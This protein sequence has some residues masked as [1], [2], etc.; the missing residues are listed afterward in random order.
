MSEWL[1]VEKVVKEKNAAILISQDLLIYTNNHNFS[2]HYCCKET[3]WPGQ[4]I[5]RKI[6]NCNLFVVSK[7]FP[8]SGWQKAWLHAHRPG[9]G[10]AESSITIMI[11]HHPLEALT[12][13]MWNKLNNFSFM[14]NLCFKYIFKYV[15]IIYVNYVLYISTPICIIYVHMHT[16]F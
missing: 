13:S 5:Q 3:S 4:L 15:R 6:F 9:P 16:Y 7:F 10:R 11:Q 1:F 2:L 12:L 8:F 14:R